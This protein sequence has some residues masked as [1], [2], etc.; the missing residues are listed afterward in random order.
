M[1]LANDAAESE[2][3]RQQEVVAALQNELSKQ[4]RKRQRL[5]DAFEEGVYDSNE[6]I[7]RKQI[8]NSAIDELKKQIQAAKSAI[9]ESVDYR[10]KIVKLHEML[11]CINATDIDPKTKNAVLKSFID[12]IDYDVEDYG[13]G[14]G[15][16]PLLHIHLK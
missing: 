16:K 9:P 2:A 3:L 8:V 7:E 13:R 5:F 10:E 15:G 6:F 12:Y 14:K 11:D 4:E 1:K